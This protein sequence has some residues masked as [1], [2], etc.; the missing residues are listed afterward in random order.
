MKITLSKSQWQFIGKKAGWMKKTASYSTHGLLFDTHTS[1]RHIP[2]TQTS[3]EEFPETEVLGVEI[4]DKVDLLEWIE[5]LKPTDYDGL[6]VTF[7]AEGKP[8]DATIQDENRFLDSKFVQKIIKEKTPKMQQD[9][10]DDMHEYNKQLNR[11]F[12]RPE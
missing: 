11:A 4:D 12:G 10:N 5:I 9:N 8:I 2:M 7:D 6:L 3:P 1:G